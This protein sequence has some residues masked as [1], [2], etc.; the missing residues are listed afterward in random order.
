M[1]NS[2]SSTSQQQ[3]QMDPI[4]IIM[5]DHAYIRQMFSKIDGELDSNFDAA[6]SDFKTLKDFLIKHE[7]MEQK[8]FYSGIENKDDLKK[9]IKPLKQQEDEAANALKK[10]DEIKDKQQWIAKYNELK[11]DVAN[12]ANDEETK[13]FPKVKHVVSS[14]DMNKIAQKM[15]EFRKNKDMNTNMPNGGMV[16]QKG[17]N[18][19]NGNGNMKTQNGNTQDG[20][21]DSSY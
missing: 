3:Q 6:K 12:H 8:V 9:I 13:L 16:S 4:A 18:S 21:T 15:M 1:S 7:T 10:F 19:Q 17:M 5:Q 2:A 20:D 11:K 14:E